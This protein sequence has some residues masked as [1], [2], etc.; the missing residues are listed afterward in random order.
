MHSSDLR[1]LFGLYRSKVSGLLLLFSFF[2]SFPVLGQGKGYVRRHLEFYD[3]KPLHFGFLF[4]LPVARYS[5]R[6]DAGY[7]NDST[8]ALSS[9]AKT[10]FRMGFTINHALSRHF[11]I[12]TTPSVSLYGRELVYNGPASEKRKIRESTWIE[13]PLLLKYKSVRRNNS[14][15][16]L[17]AGT[18]IAIETN[19][20]NKVRFGEEQLNTKKA[21][22]TLDYGVG[23][24]QFFEFFKFTPELRFSHGLV[25]MIE[26]FGP[27]TTPG[28]RRLT[29]NTISIYLNFE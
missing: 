11:D 25:N 15:M 14:R 21:D 6:F 4:A 8:L 26:T 12:R 29:T 23:F 2:A 3:D 20:K 17:L 5:P 16:Y 27:Q 22:L 24:E 9:P 1:Y 18:T 7:T 19:V 10:A 13:I 28:I